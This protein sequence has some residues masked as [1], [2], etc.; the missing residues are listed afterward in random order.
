MRQYYKNVEN[1]P[2]IVG[3]TA[4]PGGADTLE[5]AVLKLKSLLENLDCEKV[6]T[7]VDFKEEMNH[8]VHPA[9]E[10]KIYAQLSKKEALMVGLIVNGL[11]VI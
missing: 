10:Q 2:K 7:P 8:Y 11:C 4:S 9:E 5:E 3:L 6:H 1:K